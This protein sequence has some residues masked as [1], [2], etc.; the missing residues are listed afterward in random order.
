MLEAV[1]EGIP[2]EGAAAVPR[3]LLVNDNADARRLLWRVLDRGG[4]DRITE[5]TD[6]REAVEALSTDYFDLIVTDVHMP[7]LDGW[8]LAR[9]V[10]SGVFN[11]RQDVPI[12]V[13]SATFG[14]RIAQVTAREYGVN[15]FLA[16]D[17]ARNLDEVLRGLLRERGV[18]LSKPRLLVIEDRP[19][20]QRLIDRILNKRFEVEICGDGPSGLEAWRLGRHDLVLLDVMLP[21]MSGYQVLREILRE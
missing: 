13:V 21:R 3:I 6:G 1:A 4:F 15:R 5:A 11:S 9:M 20:T 7:H 19:D 16:L 14:E 12:V 17:E 8:R 18:E 10:R 2:R